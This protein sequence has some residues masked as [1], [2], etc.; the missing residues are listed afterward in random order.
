MNDGDSTP[1][2]VA[3]GVAMDRERARLERHKLEL[4][5]MEQELNLLS[6]S[7]AVRRKHVQEADALLIRMEVMYARWLE[8]T[9]GGKHG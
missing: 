9:D 4:Q 5:A 6:R 8:M 3:Y 1:L 7:V 2:D